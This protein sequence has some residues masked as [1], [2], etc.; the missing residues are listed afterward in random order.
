MLISDAVIGSN[1]RHLEARNVNK[2]E[3]KQCGPKS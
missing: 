2:K 1:C 3:K